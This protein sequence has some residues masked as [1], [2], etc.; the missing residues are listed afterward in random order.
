M[1]ATTP[2]DPNSADAQSMSIFVTSLPSE[3]ANYRVVKT[4]A[5]GN[6]N[7][8]NAMSLSLG[9][10][11]VTVS[12]VSFARSVKFQFSSGL[13]EFTELMV[14]GGPFH[15][16]D[17]CE[18]ADGDGICDDVDSCV[19]RMHAE[20]ATVQARCTN[21]DAATFLK[22]IAIAKVTRQMLWASVEE[23][24]I[25]RQRQWNLHFRRR[26]RRSFGVLRRGT[27]WDAALNQCIADAAEDLCPADL[28]GMVGV[29]RRFVAIL[30]GFWSTMLTALPIKH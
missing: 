9:L 16:E 3:G 17:G 30:G 1:T 10:N 5:N 24:V 20:S 8:G 2:D 19:C 15:V 13:I 28:D 12:A 26:S 25:R 23:A 22:E 4:V 6:W 27:T 11:D 29:D 21:A 7:N 18:D 14:N